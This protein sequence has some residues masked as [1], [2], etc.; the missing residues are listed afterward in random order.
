MEL[1]GINHP[2]AAMQ[3]GAA[4]SVPEGALPDPRTPASGPPGVVRARR[5]AARGCI[6]TA[7]RRRE[8]GTALNA[9]L[10][11]ADRARMREEG[12]GVGPHRTV[13]AVRADLGG[14]P[15]AR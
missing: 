1:L 7:A 15:A 13:G 14:S 9:C 8:Y 11:P 4:D 12:C 6:G 10:H 2:A 5:G 3:D